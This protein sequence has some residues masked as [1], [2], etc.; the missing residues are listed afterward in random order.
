LLLRGVCLH[1][2]RTFILVVAPLIGAALSIYLSLTAY[3]DCSPGNYLICKYVHASSYGQFF[4]IPVAWIGVAG[5]LALLVA[6]VA[7]QE[8]LL[9]ILAATGFLFELR[10]VYAQAAVMKMFC[11]W[12]MA[13]A[14]VM[15]AIFWFAFEDE[16]QEMVVGS[17]MPV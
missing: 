15:T 13:S 16:P 12:C 5:Y 4:G 8:L 2:C 6:V 3:G 9:K 7:K 11:P 14:F 17:G 1:R 10:L